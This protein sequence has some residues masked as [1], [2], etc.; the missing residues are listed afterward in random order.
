MI[1]VDGREVYRMEVNPDFSDF[2]RQSAKHFEMKYPKFAK[3]DNLGKLGFLS[4]E[5]LFRDNEFLS[6]YKGNRIGIIFQNGSSS[7]STDFK[8]QATIEDKENYFP[9]PAVFVYTL[10]NIV[11]GE[12]CI[13]HHINGENNLFVFETFQ[14]DF[15]YNYIRELFENNRIDGCLAGWLDYGIDNT[16]KSFLFLIEKYA[17]KSVI[18][19]FENLKKLYYSEQ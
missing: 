5:I 2:M 8:H 18:L 13:R 11:I 16:Y 9:S 17:G 10:P 12:I 3:M 6:R 1:S 7:L 19:K 15:L 4:A 14:P